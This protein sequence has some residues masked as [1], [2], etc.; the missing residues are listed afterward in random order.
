MNVW[1]SDT[2][3]IKELNKTKKSHLLTQ[4]L[5]FSSLLFSFCFNDITNDRRE[6]SSLEIIDMLLNA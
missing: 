2:N 1:I 4:S 6:V 5:L 3:S